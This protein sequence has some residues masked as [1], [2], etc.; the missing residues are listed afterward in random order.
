MAGPTDAIDLVATT[1]EPSFAVDDRSLIIAWNPAAE[2]LLGVEESGALGEPCHEVVCG[3]DVFGN[4]FC[5]ES[6]ALAAMAQRREPAR[7][8]EL[9]IRGAYGDE[10]RVSIFPIVVRGPRPGRFVIVHL[11]QPTATQLPSSG[12]P[13]PASTVHIRTNNEPA[14][15]EVPAL[16]G[17]ETE[18]LRLLDRGAR[19][20][21]IARNLGISAKTVRNH[22]QN[23][24]QKVNA[25]SR[26]EAVCTARLHGLI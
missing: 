21:D 19:T 7:H 11:L 18:V 2:A 22:I 24:F 17:R 4:R 5:G 20:G 16:T 12:S 10:L 13:S 6:C 15:S 25:H 3:R 26:L 8:F 9:D 1:G 23:I 14:A